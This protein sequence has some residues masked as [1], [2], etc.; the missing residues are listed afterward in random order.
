MTNQGRARGGRSVS[1]HPPVRF[2]ARFA[3]NLRKGTPA[4]FPRVAKLA[5]RG[6]AASSGRL[7]NVL[8]ALN[9]FDRPAPKR[10]LGAD[11]MLRARTGPEFALQHKSVRI[12][13]RLL[14]LC[15]S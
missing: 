14:A 6:K 13:R 5:M 3:D 4:I 10:A 7:S 1:R 15:Q 8:Y 2:L 12:D 11:A 9:F